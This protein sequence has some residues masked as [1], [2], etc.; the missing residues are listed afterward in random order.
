MQIGNNRLNGP[1]PNDRKNSPL[2]PDLTKVNRE[3][4]EK[5]SRETSEKTREAIEQRSPA[6]RK[7]AAQGRDTFERSR[8]QDDAGVSVEERLANARAQRR[9]ATAER[10]ANARAQRGEAGKAERIAN[11]RNQR[12]K[13]TG[14]ENAKLAGDGSDVGK[15]VENARTQRSQAEKAERVENARTQR[16]QVEKAERVA[17]AR[18]QRVEAEKAE[19]I[20]NA[21]QQRTKVESS[22]SLSRESVELSSTVS[23]LAAGEL[24]GPDGV[25]ESVADRQ[26]RFDALRK[27]YQSGELNSPERLR[28][29]AARLLGE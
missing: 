17:N 20:T 25:E 12:A 5:S 22:G 7:E 24:P 3:G 26:V 27:A 4:I 29:A 19:R 28:K 6:R 8:P 18:A 21:R 15:R 11:A 1:Q 16:S 14:E 23:K 9:E 10:A 13:A 2:D